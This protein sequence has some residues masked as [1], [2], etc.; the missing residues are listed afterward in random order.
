MQILK[1][2]HFVLLLIKQDQNYF[3][4]LES[5]LSKEFHLITIIMLLNH[6]IHFKDFP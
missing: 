6:F 5:N 3:R 1:I 2:D 4:F